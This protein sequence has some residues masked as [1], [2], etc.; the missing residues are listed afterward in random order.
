MESKAVFLADGTKNE[1]LLSESEV[2]QELE[3]VVGSC[4]TEMGSGE[5][6]FW[7]IRQGPPHSPSLQSYFKLQP[8]ESHKKNRAIQ[9]L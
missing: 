9:Q 4:K 3:E 5:E 2:R 6:I 7:R 8:L 1:R